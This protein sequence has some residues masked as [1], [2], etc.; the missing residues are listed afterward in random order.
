MTR[1]VRI[2]DNLDIEVRTTT[3]NGY[4]TR[5]CAM[6]RNVDMRNGFKVDLPV[7]GAERSIRWEERYDPSA[8]NMI[9]GIGAFYPVP[10]SPEAIDAMIAELR[11]ELE[12]AQL[13][14]IAP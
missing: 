11:S 12:R 6:Q 13:I 14:Q 1:R 9:G 7:K 10:P 8:R 3:D 2:G 4:V 5:A